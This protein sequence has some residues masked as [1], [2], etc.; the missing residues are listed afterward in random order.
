MRRLL[1]LFCLLLACCTRYGTPTPAL[2]VVDGLSS[3]VEGETVYLTARV[4]VLSGVEEAGFFLGTSAPEQVKVSA[5]I[6]EDGLLSS[7]V[8]ALDYE[9]LYRYSA[10]VRNGSWII[11]SAQAE[12][13]TAPAPELPQ[14]PVVPDDPAEPTPTAEPESPVFEEVSVVPRDFSATVQVRLHGAEGIDACGIRMGDTD[15]ACTWEGSG[16]QRVLRD[17]SPDTDYTLSAYVIR[18]GQTYLSDPVSFRTDAF[19]FCPYLWAWLL[20][21]YDVNLDGILSPQEYSGVTEIYWDRGIPYTSL[22]GLNLFPNL[23]TIVVDECPAISEV[24]FSGNPVIRWIELNSLSLSRI[25]LSGNMRLVSLSLGGNALEEILFPRNA[26][27]SRLWISGNRLTD[28]DVSVLPGLT[29]L[30]CS[31]N[32]LTELDLRS[33]LH[34]EELRTVGTPTL[35]LIRLSRNAPIRLLEVDPHTE[36]RF[37]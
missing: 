12:F 13:R 34:L 9:T 19:S 15:Y 28:L 4:S 26:S 11:K 10:F 30:H 21:R 24:D 16:F 23:E 14:D 2:P 27:L 20:R 33:N 17:L 31:G 37:E 5:E 1:P 3:R 36:V 29:L 22:A 18:R 32:P 7:E 8:A 6:G 35:R 25:D